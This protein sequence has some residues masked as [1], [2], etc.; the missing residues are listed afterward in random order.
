[1]TALLLAQAAASA[2]DNNTVITVGM[3][4]GGLGA[5][6]LLT[7]IWS[8][9]KP[10]KNMDELIAAA[11][12][13]CKVQCEKNLGFATDDIKKIQEDRQRNMKDLWG[14]INSLKGTLQTVCLDLTRALGRLEGRAEMLDAVRDVVA[15]DK[16]PLP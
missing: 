4:L 14:E 3:I 10:Q 13:T 1:M 9:V 11:L 16:K 6:K 12:G 7:G 8:D 2:L 15:R 5:I